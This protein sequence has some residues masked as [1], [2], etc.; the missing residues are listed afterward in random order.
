MNASGGTITIPSINQTRL[1]L[2]DAAAAQDVDI[3]FQVQTDILASGVDEYAYFLSRHVSPNTEYRGQIRFDPK[4]NIL[5]RAVRINNGISTALGS[6]TKVAGVTHAVNTY[7]WVHAQIVGTNPTTIRIKVWAD[8][9]A[10]PAT[11]QYSVTD[12][13]ASL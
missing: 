10:E 2:L 13:A 11:W 3:V 8:D 5:V 6:D 7:I 12:S 9:Q 1:A 4:R